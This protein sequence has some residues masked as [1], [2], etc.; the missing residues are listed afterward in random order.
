M[1]AVLYIRV[2]T[3]SQHAGVSIQISVCK[4][5]A[6]SLGLQDTHVF[7]D[8][9]VAHDVPLEQRPGLSK[10][11]NS[12]Q[13]GDVFICTNQDRISRSTILKVRFFHILRKLGVQFVSTLEDTDMTLA[14]G[15]KITRLYT[16]NSIEYPISRTQEVAAYKKAK[17]EVTGTVPY[18]FK[19]KE[20]GNHLVSCPEEQKVIATARKLHA[21]GYSLRAIQQQLS[22]QGARTRKGT[23]HQLTQIARI[24]K[25]YAKEQENK[26][27]GKRTLPYGFKYNGTKVEHCPDEQQIVNL[28]KHLRCQKL[29][30]SKIT[31]MLNRLGYR[32]RT[33]NH[34]CISQI[35]RMLK[36]TSSLPQKGPG[37]VPYGF[38]FCPAKKSIEPCHREQ[39]VIT[40]AQA[41]RA[42]GYSLK[43][44]A[45]ELN[46]LGYKSRNNTLFMP[47]QAAKMVSSIKSAPATKLA[48]RSNLPYGYRYVDQTSK[49]ESCPQEQKVIT[50]AIELRAQGLSLR[51]I[52]REVNLRGYRTRAGTLFYI[53]QIARMLKR[54]IPQTTR[55]FHENPQSTL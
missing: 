19:K 23:E 31:D 5:K 22:L 30:L 52:T 26:P 46:Q 20:S 17:E 35:S 18:G 32:G 29:T 27:R 24:L 38:M 2:S 50:V 1:K 54:H 3:K 6:S 49:T 34:F 8:S 41:L 33:G 47:A 53:S 7:I 4:E 39:E 11:L 12:L 44:I 51:Q 48:G 55:S 25:S 21:S 13:Y 42:Q 9:D 10:S 43:A 37:T 36:R 16:E 40:K 15:Y 28:A 45:H 14:Q